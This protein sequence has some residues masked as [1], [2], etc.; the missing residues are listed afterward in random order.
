MS[1]RTRD[2]MDN[3]NLAK[4]GIKMLIF[5]TPI[6]L[7]KDNFTIKH[8]LNKGLKFKKVI[9]DLRFVMK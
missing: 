9:E 3:T 6:R 1:V 4:E 5:L 8:T 7:N 2:L